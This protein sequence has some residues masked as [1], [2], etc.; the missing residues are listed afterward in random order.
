MAPSCIRTTLSQAFQ[1]SDITRHQLRKSQYCDLT[2][3]WRL[4]NQSTCLIVLRQV[5]K[6]H[7]RKDT[8][9]QNSFVSLVHRRVVGQNVTGLWKRSNTEK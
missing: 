4:T 5:T 6:V 9:G 3:H 8:T 7:L 1:S 2:P